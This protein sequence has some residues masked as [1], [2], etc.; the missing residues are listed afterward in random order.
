[1]KWMIAPLCLAL[2]GQPAFAGAG[3]LDGRIVTLNTETTNEDGTVVFT[4]RGRT[5]TVGGL[6]EFALLP[7]GGFNGFDVVPVE[8]DISANRIEFSYGNDRGQFWDAPFNGYV[9]RF[10]VECAL[11]EAFAIDEA[12]TTMPVTRDHIRTEGGALFIDVA[13]MDYGPE[14]RLALDF[15]VSDCLLG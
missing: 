11:F 8:V 2:M 6:V 4:S 3:S 5:V 9:L 10:E 15:R 12:F 7:E 14:A 13:D 1:M